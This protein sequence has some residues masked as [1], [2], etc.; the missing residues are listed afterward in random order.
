VLIAAVVLAI[1]GREQIGPGR[2][3]GAVAVVAGIALISL[4]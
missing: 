2:L 3:V 4:G 1:G